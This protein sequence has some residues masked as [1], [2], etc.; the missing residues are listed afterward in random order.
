[1]TQE[2][3]ERQSER[4][5]KGDEMEKRYKTDSKIVSEGKKKKDAALYPQ[6]SIKL[7]AALIARVRLSL[8]LQQNKHVSM[9]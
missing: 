4:G 8:A 9:S 1:M 2:V 3:E 6:I 7:T 5:K